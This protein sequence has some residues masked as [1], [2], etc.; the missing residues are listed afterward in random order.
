[1]MLGLAADFTGKA[2]YRDGAV[3]AMDYV[4]GRNPLDRSYVTG[5]GA[6]PMRNPHHR[7][8]AQPGQCPPIPSPPAGVLSGGPNSTS[9]GRSGGQD[10]EGQVPSADLLDRR[11]PRLHPERGRGQLE[12]PTVLVA[13]WL[14]ER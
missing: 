3:D 6:R 9:H 11:L 1:M 7:F 14:D 10:H 4:L 13:T 12:R 5:H 2:A 8:W